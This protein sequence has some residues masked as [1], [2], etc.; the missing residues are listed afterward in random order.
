MIRSLRSKLLA[1]TVAAVVLPALLISMA[2]R[3]IGS[4]ALKAR[5][6]QQQT[7]LARRIAEEV[8]G[9]IRKGQSLIRMVARSS[10]FSAGS[11]IDQ[12][13]TLRN[14]LREAPAFQ[15]VMFV[16][17]DGDE[18]LKVSQRDVHPRLLHRRGRVRE[19]F[20]GS[21]FFSGN[22]APT[23][24]M[25]EPVSSFANPSRSGA[26]L[27][28]L[29]FMSLGTLMRQVSESMAGTAFIVDQKGVVLA[30]PDDAKV[31]AHTNFASLPVVSQW[32]AHPSESTSLTEYRDDRNVPVVALA[33]PIP[34]LKAAVVIEQPEA[35]VFA[36]LSRM[37][38]EF[39]IWTLV[40]VAFFLSL[41][42]AVAWRIL[43]PLHQLREAV[44]KV[45]H[46]DMAVKLDIHTHD[47]LEELGVAFEG[48]ARNLDELQHMRSDLINMIVH[49]LKMPL[50][51]IL[52]SLDSLLAG[53]LGA[54]SKE[55]AHFTRMAYR[56]SQEMLML[57]QNLLDVSRMEEGKLQLHLEPFIAADWAEAVVAP[58]RPLA[59]AN[60]KRLEL[61]V[62]K[63]LLPVNGDAP[64]LG[65]VLG[66][67]VSNALRHTT[68]S[69]G[70]VFVTLYRDGT[71]LA[72]QVRDNGEGIP[73]QDQKR[74]FEKFTQGSGKRATILSGTGLGL[75]FCK[76]V[77]EAHNG[78]ISVFSQPDEGSLFTFYLP[79]MPETPAPRDS[80]DL[81]DFVDLLPTPGERSA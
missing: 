17:D 41:A 47:E 28:K 33:S 80:D 77:V 16:S 62:A 57:V 59:E 75:T 12:Y 21:P 3:S 15:E 50:S 48:M 36:P 54:L 51:T 38:V 4:K 69:E 34:L 72:V 58:F 74:I 61:I 42:V 30:H 11:R 79:M 19:S 5:I 23:V 13:E 52:P 67:L 9:D 40:C 70:E 6:Q 26:V 55:Q 76:M 22:R 73:E 66:N 14:L 56:S 25:G 49:D 37:R 53:D 7:E 20:V 18:L 35:S 71:Q 8:D 39:I 45:G 29:S 43:H 78:R 27:A 64:L 2:Q 65:R 46:G 60:H 24:L 1:L 63:D 10:S 68:P 32:L 31:F 44:E 81:L